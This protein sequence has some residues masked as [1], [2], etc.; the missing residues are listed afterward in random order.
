MERDENSSQD[1]PSLPVTEGC[2]WIVKVELVDMISA[3]IIDGVRDDP[4]GTRKLKR[5]ETSSG[6][7]TDDDDGDGGGTMIGRGLRRERRVSGW[8]FA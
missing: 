1:P 7:V 6:V 2:V 5:G 3:T 8:Y 4:S